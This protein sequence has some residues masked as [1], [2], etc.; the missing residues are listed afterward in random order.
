[1][2]YKN[3]L[4]D[5]AYKLSKDYNLDFETAMDLCCEGTDLLAR[6]YVSAVKNDY[7]KGNN[8]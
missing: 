8:K 5:A 6:F 4:V 2:S 1:M 7:L 3:I